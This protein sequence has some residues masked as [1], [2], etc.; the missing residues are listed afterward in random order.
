MVKHKLGADTGIFRALGPSLD[1]IYPAFAKEK[2]F[3]PE[4]ITLADGTK[5]YWIGNPSAETT[6]IWFHGPLS[7]FFPKPL[8]FFRFPN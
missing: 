8:P 5:A 7:I 3:K 1:E 4:H 6:I 2:G